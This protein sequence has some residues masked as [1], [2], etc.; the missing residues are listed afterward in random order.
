MSLNHARP[1]K[2]HMTKPVSSSGKI[3]CFINLSDIL[4]GLK[5]APNEYTQFSST[6]WVE[7]LIL[8]S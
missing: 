3:T 4:F 1:L 8:K 6:F 7:L 5:R 2:L